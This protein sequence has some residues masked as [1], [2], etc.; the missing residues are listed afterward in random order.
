MV[1]ILLQGL[2]DAD[3]HCIRVFLSFRISRFSQVEA[4]GYDDFVTSLCE[5]INVLGIIFCVGG[6]NILSPVDNAV[7]F[8]F[9]T[10]SQVDWLKDL[11]ST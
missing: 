7:S 11:S 9:W 10:P 6:F 3:E 4:G 8:G 1:L 5:C 2:I